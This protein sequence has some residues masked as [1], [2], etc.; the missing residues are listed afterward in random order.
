VLVLK[1]LAEPNPLPASAPQARG[2]AGH[3]DPVPLVVDMDGTLLRTD[4]LVE[5]VFALARAKPWL[6]W[7][8]PWWLAQGRAVFKRRLAERVS[9]NVST[10]PV[11]PDLLRQL[12]AQ[13]RAGRRLVLATGADAQL[14]Q[15]VAAQ[16]ALFD[17]VLASDGQVN[18]SGERKRARLVA[19][20]GVGGFDYAG[21][22][23]RDLPVWGAARRAWLVHAPADVSAAA[24]RVAPI[25]QVF[26]PDRPD[27]RTYL[28]AMRA[29]HSLKNL[30]LL[31]PLLAAHRLYEP[32][33]LLHALLALLCFSLTACGVYLL[34][35]LL[36]LPADRQH[37][38]KRERALA[39]GRLPVLHALLGV[40]LL[41]GAAALLALLLPRAFGLT[42]AGYALLM[43][44]YSMWLKDIAI[45]D[46][47]VLAFGYSLRIEAGAL[48][49]GVAVS[50]WLLVCSVALFFG[51]A[52]LKRYAELVTQRAH[53]NIPRRVR[54]YSPADTALIVALGTASG[55]IAVA[56]LALYPAVE[57][58]T[59]PPAL[60]WL[61][62]AALLLWTGH[63]WRM[64]QRGRIRD[65]PVSFALR[66]PASRAFGLLCVA[67]MLLNT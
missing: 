26:E 31:V 43:V 34:N 7:L 51:L 67:L 52:L 24:A 54:G 19:E 61:L 45:V 49:T 59:E 20:F 3:A 14:A 53:A 38:H 60:L 29:Q 10:L 8:L 58:V 18:L 6:L 66:D 22:S 17:T 5:L 13:R 39:A 23:T 12:R 48:A 46:T 62:S 63:M 2:N 1:P 56:V 4:T 21:N 35:D 32:A 16:F 47:L 40:P 25:E 30:L 50:A 9:L 57:A 64:A 36:D 37:P 42:L 41:W 27:W 15:A 44:M 11:T 33:L 28:G 55:C 65:D